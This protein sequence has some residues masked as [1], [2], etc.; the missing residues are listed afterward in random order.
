MLE[1]DN[2]R[3]K[4]HL[5]LFIVSAHHGGAGLAEQNSLS[6][7]D[8]KEGVREKGMKGEKEGGRERMNE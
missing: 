7:V 6:M 1:P 3:G 4:N 8:R 5:F 2:I